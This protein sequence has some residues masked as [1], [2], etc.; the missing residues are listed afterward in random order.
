MAR[1]CCLTQLGMLL[2]GVCKVIPALGLYLL[3]KTAR[4]ARARSVLELGNRR[5]PNR[6]KR[7]HSHPL[8]YLRQLGNRRFHFSK[9]LPKIADN[10]S[11]EIGEG[12]IAIS[13]SK[14]ERRRAGNYHQMPSAEEQSR[15]AKFDRKHPSLFGAGRILLS[16]GET[17]RIYSQLAEKGF[18]GKER[19]GDE[20]DL[21]SAY[22]HETDPITG[23]V[24]TTVYACEYLGDNMFKPYCRA[25]EVGDLSGDRREALYNRIRKE[26]DTRAREAGNR[27]R[28]GA[29]DLVVDLG[30]PKRGGDDNGASAPNGKGDKAQGAGG[31]DKGNSPLPD[32]NNAKAE[33][34]DV[35]YL[36]DRAGRVLGWFDPQ[37]KEVHLLP[38]A[39]PRTVAHEIMCSIIPCG[40]RFCESLRFSFPHF[41][42][43]LFPHLPEVPRFLF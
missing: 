25:V 42:P 11:Y 43:H 39:D 6:R 33:N 16:K 35:S 38:G 24:R 34:G 27:L 20:R 22:T 7:L 30:E 18:L 19:Y 21:F 3:P 10:R 4:S 5:F 14:I 15:I 37:S 28:N 9:T 26:F 13:F 36:R 32:A 40:C 23:T 31:N 17:A 29:G 2:M 1:L 8:S 12:L 41:L